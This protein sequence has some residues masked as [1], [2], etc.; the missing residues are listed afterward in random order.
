MVVT[1]YNLNNDKKN[2]KMFN[3]D[4]ILKYVDFFLV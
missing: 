4:A 3:M 2:S 1:L